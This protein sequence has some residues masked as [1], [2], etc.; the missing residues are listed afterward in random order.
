[1]R[2]SFSK[3]ILRDGY[4]SIDEKRVDGDEKG[5]GGV[6]GRDRTG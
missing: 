6:V 1:M 4:S 5:G 3:T 2:D